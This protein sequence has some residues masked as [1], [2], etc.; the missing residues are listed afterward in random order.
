MSIKK[1][2]NLRALDPHLQREK[3]R[4]GH[5]L[6]SREFMLQILEE[7]GVPVN[8]K[9]LRSLLEIIEEEE[10]IFGRR[11]SAML[12]EGQ[13]MRNR[14]GDICVVEK[15]DLIKGR[16][17]GHADGFGFLIPDDASPDLFLSAKEMH[18]ALH[19]DRVMVR[20]IGVDRRGRR[21]AAIV[22]VLERA[23]TQLVGRL[24]ADHGILFV[25]AENKRIS[26]DILI[27][28]EEST[29]A[30]AGQ[31]VIV[32]IIQQPSKH[33]QPIGRI[34]EVL[35]EY[36]APGMEI[37]IAVRKYDLPYQ[38]P[39]QVKKLSDKF[40]HKVTEGELTGRED[41]R[42]LPLVTIDGETARD[43][44]DAVYCERDGKGYKLY[45]AIADVSHYVQTRDALDQEAFN[46]G[47]S[48]YFPRRVIP[49]LPEVLSNGLCSL[50]PQVE[51]LCM[52]CEMNID[53]LGDFGGYRF[54]PAVMFSHARLTYT[55]VAAMLEDP[56]GEDA[57]QHNK[58]LPH[59]QLLHKLFKILLKARGKRGAIDFETI[60]TQMVFNDQGK[61][62]RILPVKRN[63]AHRLI[64][65]CMLAANVCAS[66]FLQKH[67]QPTLYRIHEGP[68]P[69][70][71]VALRDF[72]K[73]FGV[74]LRGGDEP[75]AKDYAK[76]LTKIKDRPDA[77]LL[78]TVMLRSLRQAVY[79]P[80]NVGH[81]G[82][83]YESYTHFTSPIRRY[84]DLLVHRAI[85]AVLNGTVYTP[86]NWHELGEHCS[87]TE[88]RADDASRDV[89]SWLKCF[90][91]QDKVGE[92][93]DGVISGV[94][95]FG[96]FVALD[97]IYVEG[98]VHI[99]EL[100]SDYFHFDPGKHMLLGE[101]TGKR[102]RLGDRLRVEV[103]RVDLETSKIDF[104]LTNNCDS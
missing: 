72:L 68:T 63:D 87:L 61:I 34:V 36:T 95:G 97:G 101:R 103:A 60:E 12:R 20:E 46:R 73:E 40:P 47:N 81:F 54:Y 18:K 84:P 50:N 41:L 55:K 56:K 78:Q 25:E 10:E 98:L 39:T 24:H 29:G 75:Q 66:D 2:R 69:E 15:L 93:F 16:V 9:A 102:Y 43:F 31:V 3:E 37:E 85:K 7:Q 38:F 104:V 71:L 48:V 51:R 100:P 91:M 59:I 27:P 64:E 57:T 58:L 67:K 44:D 94:T 76:T 86:G 88:R 13:I 32:E 5:A 82:L 30:K 23:V 26:Q 19:G 90:Y 96:L 99:S 14:K 89:E 17:Q 21:E 79:S 22:E 53:P 45:V 8:E 1:R 33:A 80:D 77:Q 35:G 11:V 6:P 65:E 52:V 83:A 49:M 28:P 4:Y 74:Q 92:C 70:K 62:E 42:H